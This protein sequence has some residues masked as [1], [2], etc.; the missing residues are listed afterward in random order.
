MPCQKEENE[1]SEVKSAKTASRG[2]GRMRVSDPVAA[3]LLTPPLAANESGSMPSP[4]NEVPAKSGKK[5]G[6]F[7]CKPANRR[8]FRTLRDEVGEGICRGVFGT[9]CGQKVHHPPRAKTAVNS[10]PKSGKQHQSKTA[11]GTFCG[12]KV[13]ST[14]RA[15]TAVVLVPLQARMRRFKTR[16]RRRWQDSPRTCEHRRTPP[17]RMFVCS[18]G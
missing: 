1:R 10:R 4:S 3:P 13:Q 12:Q 5:R 15:K 8:P 18:P 16:F 2:D 11:I 14:P 7:A 17:V 6:R 9:F